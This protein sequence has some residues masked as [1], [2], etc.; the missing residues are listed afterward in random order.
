MDERTRKKLEAQYAAMTHLM[1]RHY[2]AL[3]AG[4]SYA[5]ILQ[6]G[7]NAALAL[8]LPEVAREAQHPRR[9]VAVQDCEASRV[10]SQNPPEVRSK[11]PTGLGMAALLPG[12]NPSEAWGI[13]RSLPR[14][15]VQ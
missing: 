3:P 8:C 10:V 11:M 4:K 15:D 1:Q 7:V 9:A 2:G 6:D 12:F 13:G 5:A 14:G